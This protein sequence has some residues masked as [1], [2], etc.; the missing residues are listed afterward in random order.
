MA[1]MVDKRYYHYEIQAL[2]KG[3]TILNFWSDSIMIIFQKWSPIQEL[4]YL[5]SDFNLCTWDWETPLL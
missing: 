2:N 4:D 1:V 3:V 5:I